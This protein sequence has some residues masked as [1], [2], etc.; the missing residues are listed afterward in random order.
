MKHTVSDIENLELRLQRAREEN[1]EVFERVEKVYQK[2]CKA[3]I[4][5]FFST[6][7]L[8]VKKTISA[9]F[10]LEAYNTLSQN[11]ASKKSGDI[12][13]RKCLEVAV[14]KGIT[15]LPIWEQKQQILKAKI[16]WLESK[17]QN[18]SEIFTKNSDI[19]HDHNYPIL[20]NLFTNKQL[21][22]SDMLA[23]Y[24]AYKTTGNIRNALEWI[25]AEKRESILSHFYILN[26]DKSDEK[27]SDF[28][29][30]YHAEIASIQ[31]QYSPNIVAGVV[32]FVWRNFFKMKPLWNKKESPK[33]RIQRTFT[34]ALLKLLRIKNW[35]I[36]REKLLE[37]LEN[38][39]DFQSL[40]D[41][42]ASI[43]EIIPESEELLEKYS[44]QDEVDTIENIV[45][46]AE[47]T[48]E[49][50][51]KWEATTIKTCTL[52]S[53]LEEWFDK[54]DLDMLLDEHTDLVWQEYIVR[55]QHPVDAN[56]LAEADTQNNIDVSESNQNSDED[57]EVD[58]E[59]VF[60][61]LKT[62]FKTLEAQKKQSF[63]TG[64]Y[65]ELDT[66]NEELLNIMTKME[67][68]SVTK[69]LTALL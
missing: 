40:F 58:L 33:A 5:S 66:I 59:T 30:E 2:E 6:D 52:I 54:Q 53:R 57:E 69:G 41:L 64:D 39:S 15:I 45:V 14:A 63:L 27:I 49:K 51:L 8:W 56:V 67:K 18:Y 19:T 28:K 17:K 21:S 3:F 11:N 47:N 31:Q 68:L 48:K 1:F 16:L 12:H 25:S 29:N 43:I 7:I 10:Q 32:Q 61:N 26:W 24:T 34:I 62:E 42:I 36:S 50:L 46:T 13:T 65:D 55:G 60:T 44:L 20:E 4:D 23:I 35:S 9:Y 22:Q 38:C 37:K